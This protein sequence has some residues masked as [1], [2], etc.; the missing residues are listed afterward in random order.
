MK[1]IS[2]VSLV[3]LCAVTACHKKEKTD[4]VPAEKGAIGVEKL[5]LFTF[6]CGTIEISD[7]DGFSTDGDYAGIADTF[8]DTCYLVRHPKGDLL[9]D[10]GLPA[11]LK[12]GEPQVNGVFTVSLEKTITEQLAELA[13]TPSDVDY[14]SISHSHFDHS[15]QAEQFAGTTWLVNDA[16]YEVMFGEGADSAPYEAFKGLKRQSFVGDHDVFGDGTVS[17]IDLP[18]HTPGHTGLMLQLEDAGTVL[19]TGDLYHRAESRKLKR[20]PRFNSDEAQTRESIEKF[21][22]LVAVTN[23]RVIIQ[24]EPDD[25]TGLPVLPN[26]LR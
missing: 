11:A 12:E 15:G 2:L 21:E 19:L 8:T 22:S 26:A 14:I 3:A 6:E 10:L 9:W 4:V 25:I 20:V 24:H 13:L 23:A 17:I 1:I 5:A 7:L 18:G 16:E